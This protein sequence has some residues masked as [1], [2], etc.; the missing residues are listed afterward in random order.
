M[1]SPPDRPLAY[2]RFRAKIDCREGTIDDGWTNG[3]E[4]AS[5]D[6][7]ELKEKRQELDMTQAQ[8]A[9]ALGVNVTTISRWERNLRSIP[10]HLP[11]ALEA[12]KATNKRKVSKKRSQGK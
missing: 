11:L 2:F 10:P 7:E 1:S 5:M 12:I 8:L 9:E 6:G 4:S 3:L